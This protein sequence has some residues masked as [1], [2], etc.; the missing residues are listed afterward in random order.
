MLRSVVQ[1]GMLT[2]LI[3]VWTGQSA[4]AQVWWADGGRSVEP[5]SQGVIQQTAG[6]APARLSQV[7]AR[8]VSAAYASAPAPAA[9]PAPRS[10]P[11]LDAPLYPTPQPNIPWQMGGT[12]ITNQAFSPHEMMYPHT[13]RAMYPPYYYKVHGG[14]VVT[15]WGVWSHDNWRLLGTE[16]EVKYKSHHN[17]FSKFIPPVI[18]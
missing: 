11:Q 17:H 4:E 9:K 5:V 2:M 8:P 12:V 10:Y 14:W 7:S 3:S 15:P 1:V 16:V 6:R 18:R 13:Y